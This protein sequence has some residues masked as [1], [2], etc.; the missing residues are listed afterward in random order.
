M[1]KKVLLGIYIDKYNIFQLQLLR[2]ITLI[3]LSS[4]TLTV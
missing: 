4:L 1:K 3:V 2:E